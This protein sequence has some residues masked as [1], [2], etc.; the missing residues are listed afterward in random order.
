MEKDIFMQ[1]SSLKHS[2][3]L[4]CAAFFWGITFVAQ[5]IGAAFVGPFTYLTF[6]SYLG[7][8]ILL[9]IIYRNY[10]KK[11]KE[12]TA[13]TKKERNASVKTHLMAGVLCGICL[14]FS[15]FTQQF[16]IAY[17]TV[18]K[19]SFITALYVVLV[20]V[21]SLFLGKKAPVR[22]WICVAI[23]TLGLYFL[24][25]DGELKLAFGDTIILICAVLFAIHILVVNHFNPV[26]DGL[27]LSASQ[28]FV[29]AIL[30]T[31]CMVI[32]EP[33][34]PGMLIKALPSI[35]FAGIFS[36]AI[37]YTCQIIG[38]KGV[39]PA[40]A[41]LIMCLESVFGTLAGWIVLH[42]TLTLREILGCCLMF[43]AIVMVEMGEA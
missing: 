22:V 33:I 26:T 9:P 35:A 5:D 20:P 10:K 43:A 34:E 14:F 25:I 23:C 24:C 32:W 36:N 12:G 7:T 30:A 18:A 38:Q 17:T 11:I 28:F 16:G 39:R 40:V 27:T 37:A 3:I 6:R 29:T 1:K 41:S 4:L 31:V 13:P 2:M 42:Q 8:A 19:A 15:S 21:F